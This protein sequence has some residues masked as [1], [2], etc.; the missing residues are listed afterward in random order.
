[1]LGVAAEAEF[2]RLLNVAVEGAHA[3]RFSPILRAPFIRA[4]ITKF[5]DALKPIVNKLEHHATEDLETNLAAI[6]SVIRIARNESGHPAAT[7]PPQRESVYVS[8]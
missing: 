4:K 1:V 5:H 8:L 2:L 6:Q 3:A 7:K